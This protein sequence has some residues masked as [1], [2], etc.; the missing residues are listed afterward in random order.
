MQ[1]NWIAAFL[2]IGFLVFITIRGELPQYIAVLL[3]GDVAN[4]SP[5]GTVGGAGAGAAASSSPVPPAVKK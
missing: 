2:L 5:A 4:G 1:T 3:G